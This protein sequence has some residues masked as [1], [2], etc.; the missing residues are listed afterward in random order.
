[1]ATILSEAG[2]NVD[3][4][5]ERKR[6]LLAEALC[7]LGPTPR[8]VLIIPPDFT[9][10]NSNAGEITVVLFIEG[11]HRLVERVELG[12]GERIEVVSTLSPEKE[13]PN[14]TVVRGR[15]PWP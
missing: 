7:H 9:R 5:A 4:S 14:I 10:F 6:D 15:K 13:S 11:F 8:K 12:P 2:E 1:M 3:L